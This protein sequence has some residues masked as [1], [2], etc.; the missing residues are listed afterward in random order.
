MHDLKGSTLLICPLKY[1]KM[2]KPCRW[3]TGH[4]YH[5]VPILKILIPSS[6]FFS[7]LNLKN[8]TL[9]M[10]WNKLYITG[11]SKP[12]IN[13]F[14]FTKTSRYKDYGILYQW[15]KYGNF[16]INCTNCFQNKHIFRSFIIL[17]HLRWILRKSILFRL[18]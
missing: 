18:F 9:P 11:I 13:T 12:N 8:F 15:R 2:W 4:K 10:I 6:K 1:V 16:W 5:M 3:C 14:F 7:L 17:L